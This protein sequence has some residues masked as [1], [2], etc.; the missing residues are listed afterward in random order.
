[1]TPP[2]SEAHRHDH[3]AVIGFLVALGAEDP[4]A[5]RVLQLEAYRGAARHPEEIEEILRVE[6]DLH[7][8]AVV[9]RGQGLLRLAESRRL[10]GEREPAGREAEAHG[11][12]PLG[13][14]EAHAADRGGER[15]AVE[16]ER[17]VA[18]DPDDLLER[19]ELA[20]LPLRG[21]RA[22]AHGE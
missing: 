12:A 10:G 7:G 22:P 5:L 18:R 2:A 17:L 19:R 16:A 6:T 13:G 8:V 4:L 20:L 14:Q 11:P 21:Q 1:P 9:V 15:L 3:V